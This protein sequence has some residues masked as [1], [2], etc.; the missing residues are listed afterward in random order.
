MPTAQP[1]KDCRVLVVDDDDPAREVLRAL[2]EAAGAVVSTAASVAAAWSEI[3]RSLPEVMIVDLGMPIVD[4]FTFVEQLRL[5]PAAAGG[6]VPVAAL[7]GYLSAED[8][9]RATR[10]GFQAYLVKPV[11]PADLLDTVARLARMPQSGSAG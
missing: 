8:R 1:L 3:D 9:A 2:L 6:L 5:R 10:A 4:G 7:T 11:E